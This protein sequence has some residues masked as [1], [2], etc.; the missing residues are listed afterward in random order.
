M[1]REF[2]SHPLLLPDFGIDTNKFRRFRID[3]DKLVSP[4]DTEFLQSFLFQLTGT[5]GKN[6]SVLRFC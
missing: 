5:E 2:Y 1:V 6:G 4:V 3:G